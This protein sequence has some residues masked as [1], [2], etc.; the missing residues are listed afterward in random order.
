MMVKLETIAVTARQCKKLRAAA[1]IVAKSRHTPLRVYF[2]VVKDEEGK[3]PKVPSKTTRDTACKKHLLVQVQA[4]MRRRIIT[5]KSM[6][7]V[8]LAE[9]PLRKA[10]PRGVACYMQPTGTTRPP[11]AGFNPLTV[12]PLVTMPQDIGFT[13]PLD[14]MTGSK[15]HVRWELSE[16]LDRRRAMDEDLEAMD[17]NLDRWRRLARFH[18]PGTPQHPT[19]VALEQQELATRPARQVIQA[20]IDRLNA[21][22]AARPYVARLSV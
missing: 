8:R 22:L 5:H 16:L 14:L 18:P 3:K 9:G 7:R 13:R 11:P 15:A 2:R 6:G 4:T 19:L 17:D 12:T 21:R 20:N 10:H 1:V